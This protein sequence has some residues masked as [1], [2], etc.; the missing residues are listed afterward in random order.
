MPLNKSSRLEEEEDLFDDDEGVDMSDLGEEDDHPNKK[1]KKDP[2][3]YQVRKAQNR[4]AQR[5]F[6]Q[7]KQ[8]Y[9]RDLEARVQ[10]LSSPHDE[11]MDILRNAVVA[12]I[13]ENK[14]LR[15]LL[16][17]LSSFIGSDIGGCLTSIGVG[18]PD[19]E[20]LLRRG[21]TDAVHEVFSANHANKNGFSTHA[22]G[23]DDLSRRRSTGNLPMATTSQVRLGALNNR[24]EPS[25]TFT[26]GSTPSLS[27]Y[28]SVF[29]NTADTQPPLFADPFVGVSSPLPAAASAFGSNHPTPSTSLYNP[30]ALPDVARKDSTTWRTPDLNADSGV[31]MSAFYDLTTDSPMLHAMQLIGYHLR[32]KRQNPDY[33][34]PPALQPTPLQL[35]QSHDRLIDGMIWPNVRERLINMQDRF[36]TKLVLG[37][38]LDHLEIHREDVL[39]QSNWELKEPFL[40]KY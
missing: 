37:D 3:A 39:D 34:L 5:E 15:T 24:M 14:Q 11:Q 21:D 40:R 6:R 9:V 27:T 8:A 4:V 23:H 20:A 12:L 36:D 35:K 18:A 29:Q 33:H 38:M 26:T 2:Q 19:F 17:S 16:S 32:N 31:D 13:A 1:R 10:L 28:R 30:L 22:N 25:P 7:R